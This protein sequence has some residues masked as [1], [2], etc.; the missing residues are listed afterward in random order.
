MVENTEIVVNEAEIL[1]N[2]KN[3]CHNVIK[4]IDDHFEKEKITLPFI[5]GDRKLGDL[6]LLCHECSY[7]LIDIRGNI[8]ERFGTIHVDVYGICLQCSTS[9]HHILRWHKEGHWSCFVDKEWVILD[10]AVYT[11]SLFD[12]IKK[13]FK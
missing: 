4:L 13:V 7:N 6:G 11:P 2:F 12:R 1:N 3:H 10:A 9:D 8:A 5:L